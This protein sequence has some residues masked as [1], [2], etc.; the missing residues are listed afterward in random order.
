MEDKKMKKLLILG[1]SAFL[2]ASCISEESKVAPTREPTQTRENHGYNPPLDFSSEKDFLDY[3][4]NEDEETQDERNEFRLDTLTHFYKLKNPPTDAIIRRIRV[5][6]SVVTV[7]Y[8]TQKP[9]D[10]GSE[11]MMIQYSPKSLLSPHW[12]YDIEEDGHWMNYPFPEEAYV[13]EKEEIKYYIRKVTGLGH[14]ILLWSAEWYNADKYYMY[15][16]FPHRFTAEEVL[17]F[18]SDLERV[19]IQP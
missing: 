3:V 5:T 17:G 8:D 19:E 11:H 12:S 15:S 10:D 13:F 9:N 18:V 4:Q 16:E 7:V 6:E 1:I 2:L 14:T